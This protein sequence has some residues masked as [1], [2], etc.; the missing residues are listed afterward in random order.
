ML[1]SNRFYIEHPVDALRLAELMRTI[2]PDKLSNKA[3]RRHFARWDLERLLLE[4]IVKS[5]PLGTRKSAKG[6]EG[7]L[8][9]DHSPSPV[10]SSSQARDR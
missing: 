5:A 2:L 8:N 10:T 1:L 7:A 6:A 9:E 4:H 3:I